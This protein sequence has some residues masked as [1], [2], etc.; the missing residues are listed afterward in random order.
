VVFQ[1]CLQAVDSQHGYLMLF[2]DQQQKLSLVRAVGEYHGS[3]CSSMEHQDEWPEAK[4]VC[5]HN[6]TVYIENGEC[7]V[8]ELADFSQRIAGL[9]IVTPLRASDQVVGVVCVEGLAGDKL[10]GQLGRSL[11]EILAAQAGTAIKHAGLYRMLNQKISDLNFIADYAEQ[12][13]GMVDPEDVL[14]SF[15]DTIRDYFSVAF[16]G[17][18]L[19]KKR[20]IGV[21]TIIAKILLMQSRMKQ[22]SVSMNEATIKF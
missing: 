13:V 20:Y 7:E 22:L 4:W 18:L 12:F 11:L 2:D 3:E 10:H 14:I 17:V 16:V 15:L 19:L 6:R 1:S 9:M 5:S 21:T 8:P